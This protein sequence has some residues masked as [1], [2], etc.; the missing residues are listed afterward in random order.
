M[1]KPNSFFR[2][3]LVLSLLVATQALATSSSR[4]QEKYQSAR[5]KMMRDEEKQ[6]EVLGSLFDLNQGLKKVVKER[7]ELTE[8]F[9]KNESS[10]K[11]L[12][13]KIIQMETTLRLQ[14]GV[15]RQRL[16]TIYKLG[17]HG[18]ARLLLTSSSSSDLERNLKILGVIAK[19]D[20][21]LI[22]EVSKNVALLNKRREK[23]VS[24]IEQLK[25]LKEKLEKREKLLAKEND[26]KSQILASL[27]K[28]QKIKMRELTKLREKGLQMFADSDHQ[29][30]AALLWGP[31]FFESKGKL[32]NP[33]VGKVVQGF[34]LYRDQVHEVAFGHKGLFLAAEKGSTVKS[35]F[36]GKVAFSGEVSG[37]GKTLILDHG[38]HY[39][40]VY[41]YNQE[42]KVQVGE[43]VKDRQ[44]IALSGVGSPHF[45]EGLYFEIRHF[46]EPYD[47]R[48]WMKGTL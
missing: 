1:K 5:Q 6:R 29:E 27:R 39:Y 34:G 23:F 48:T 43:E 31:A 9:L 10:A 18:I 36:R 14:K 19:A 4:L 20:L 35:I 24:R 17:G 8:D 2:G 16:L 13:Q 44:V 3:T 41:A 42:L 11:D 45:G 26:R 28:N 30:E 7:S 37:F 32:P 46:S 47:P 25:S 33:V 21:E 40:S 15:L 38:D 12:A 22:S